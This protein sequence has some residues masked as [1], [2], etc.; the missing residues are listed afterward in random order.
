MINK[1]EKIKQFWDEQAEQF[2]ESNLATAPDTYYRNLEID[3][4]ISYLKDKKNILDI[5]CGN[6]FST[7][8]FAKKF[9]HSKIL[10]IDYSKKMINYAKK[11]LSKNKKLQKR[12]EFKVGDIVLLSSLPLLEKK[13]NYIV[14]ERCLINLLNWEE[15]KKAL[16]EMKKLLKKKGKIILCENTQEG[17]TRLNNLRRQLKLPPIS[18]RWHNHYMPEKKLLNFASKY[19]YIKEINNIGSLYYIISRVVYAKLCKLNKKEPDYFNPIN[20]IASQ[21]PSMGNYSPNFIF[22]LENK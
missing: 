20:K 13:F 22:L 16:L 6:G 14:S 21:L 9:P 11:N 7:L 1:K 19:F 17:L 2:K 18:V 4:I 5:G 10:G 3:R 12:V 8:R 15:Q